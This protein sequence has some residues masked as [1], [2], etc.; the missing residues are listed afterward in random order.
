MEINLSSFKKDHGIVELFSEDMS[1]FWHTDDNLPHYINITFKKLTKVNSVVLTL[2]FSKDDSYTPSIIEIR[3]GMTRETLEP[4][5][6]LT[7]NEPE[8]DIN[9]SVEKQCFFLQIIILSN[10]QDGKDTHIRRLRVIND[11]MKDILVLPASLTK[12]YL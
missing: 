12:R 6:N 2:L 3:A 4:V 11:K 8:G 7:L 1:E 10:H 9:F 5:C